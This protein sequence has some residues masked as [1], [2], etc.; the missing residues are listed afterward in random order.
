MHEHAA[1]EA[2]QAQPSTTLCNTLNTLQHTAM[3]QGVPARPLYQFVRWAEQAQTPLFRIQ[4]G[5]LESYLFAASE[6][7]WYMY[8]CK[9]IRQSFHM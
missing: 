8:D 1:A 6:L 7:W 9:V 3:Q 5:G 4:P 2:V